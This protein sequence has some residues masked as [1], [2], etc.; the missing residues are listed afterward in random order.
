MAA[1]VALE[2]LRQHDQRLATENEML[3]VEALFCNITQEGQVST[4]H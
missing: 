4:F 1:H 2:K 3:K